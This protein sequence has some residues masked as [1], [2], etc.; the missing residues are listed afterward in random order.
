M[1]IRLIRTV[2]A[3]AVLSAPALAGG[4]NAEL[5]VRNAVKE[6]EH[7]WKKGDMSAM[8]KLVMPDFVALH[9]GEIKEAKREANNAIPLPPFQVIGSNIE[10]VEVS[11]DLAWAHGRINA[12]GV[13]SGADKRRFV[14]TRLYLLKK[15]GHRWRVAALSSN[16]SPESPSS[17]DK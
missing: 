13:P 12:T 9:N 6:F 7:A 4:Y 8:A 11:C 15:K 14:M 16:V 2:L 1:L 17:T 10:R 5:D 3:V